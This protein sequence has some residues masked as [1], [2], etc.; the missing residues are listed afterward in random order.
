M[1]T[2]EVVMTV[3]APAASLAAVDIRFLVVCTAWVSVQ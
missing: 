3:L 2:L 1:E